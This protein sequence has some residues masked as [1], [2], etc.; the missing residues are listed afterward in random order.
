MTMNNPLEVQ[1]G[2]SHYKDCLIQPVEVM[3]ILGWD[4]IQGAIFKYVARHKDKNGREDLEKAVH[5][6]EIGD[7]YAPT[8]GQGSGEATNAFIEM[9]CRVMG[10]SGEINQIMRYIDQKMYWEVKNKIELLI[11]EEYGN[12]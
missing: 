12:N 1:V 9:Y 5:F 7:S 6:A 3:T 4:Y 10:A 2:G 11:K 8:F